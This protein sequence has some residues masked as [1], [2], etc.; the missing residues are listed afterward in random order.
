MHRAIL[1]FGAVVVFGTLASAQ[2][3]MSPEQRK[4]LEKK[5]AAEKFSGK[6]LFEWEGD[7]KS[8]DPSIK[9]KAAAAIK[10]YGSA[11]QDGATPL[12]LK[13]L[14]D[15]DA[16]TRVN[17]CISLG[18]I[19]FN[20][21]DRDNGIAQIKNLL[22][23][24]EGIVRFQAAVALSN[25]GPDANFTVPALATL[26]KDAITWEI[27]GAA[28]TALATAGM[29]GNIG[30]DGRAWLALL[31]AIHDPAFEVR[32]A[33]L[34]GLLYVGKPAQPADMARENSAL[35]SLFNDRNEVIV[36]WARLCHMRI[37]GVTDEHVNAI[38]KHLKSH[39]AEARSEACR[40]FAIIG[41]EAK[42]KVNDLINHLDDKDAVTAIWACAAVAQMQ[43]AGKPAIPKLKKVASSNVDNGVKEAALQAIS[44]LG[45]D[46]K[47]EPTLQ[48]K[49]APDQKALDS[50]REAEIA[51]GK[52]LAEWMTDLRSTDPSIKLKAIANIKVY[53]AAARQANPLLL[54]ALSDRD[55][56]SRVNAC[57]TLGEIGFDDKELAEGIARI[58]PLLADSQG[59]VRYQAAKT[60]GNYGATANPAVPRL[61]TLSKDVMTWQIREAACI[62]LAT[63][64]LVD[65]KS[66]DSRAWFALVER[67]HDPC[68][69]V[70]YAALKGLL[71]LKKPA[72]AADT[73]KES[74]ELKSLFGDKSEIIA[75]WARLCYM[76]L[77]G[78]SEE[79]LNAIT[80]H[81]RSPIGDVRMESCKT[82]AIIGVEAK[83]QVNELVVCLDDKEPD[84]ALWACAALAQMKEAGKVAIPKL[85]KISKEHSNPAVR[86]AGE[87]AIKRLGDDDKAK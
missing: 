30:L 83:S 5:A 41:V 14:T 24:R 67:L 69:E 51:T 47:L 79:H 49:P 22:N 87:E 20:A 74:T 58:I 68:F 76:L 32:K 60:L 29:Q 84:V 13:A 15:K 40:A 6:T 10:Y 18:M 11:A 2:Q 8:T 9:M 55:A 72:S 63:A 42:K 82:M 77:N 45:G 73:T 33:A 7:L 85:L 86:R 12:L 27:R 66:M 81:M 53:G 19:G 25:F 56:S 16:S 1:A 80:K 64:G 48:V 38:A 52:T 36:I 37:N 43:D 23:D 71:Y 78:V 21:R 3:V 4:E 62:T 59:I 65:G 54:R 28:C 31:Q 61:T 35:L 46:A 75:M 34:Q 26:T 70:K 50:R 57:I 17:A 44:R 39:K